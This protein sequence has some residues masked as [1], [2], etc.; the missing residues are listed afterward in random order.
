[1]LP[2]R[3]LFHTVKHLKARQVIYRLFYQFRTLQ[4]SS[5][6]FVARR[7]LPLPATWPAYKHFSTQDGKT[8]AFLNSI[9]DITGGWNNPEY[10]KLW[11]YKLHYL[12]DL[13]AVGA[14]RRSSLLTDMV[15]CW[16]R[17]N[18]LPRGNGWEPYPL[19]IRIV[20]LIKFL[21]TTTT[22]AD[23][24]IN[25]SLAL[26]VEALRKQKEVHLLG[27]HYFANAKALVFAGVF[28]EGLDAE[29]WLNE[30]LDI[31]DGELNEQFLKDGGHFEL[32]PM[33]HCILLWDLCDLIQL[34]RWSILA[35]LTK[36]EERLV[37]ALAAG[38]R[39]LREMTHPDGGISFF[40][41]A[42]FD[43]APT[44]GDIEAYAEKL[45]IEVLPIAASVIGATWSAKHMAASGYVSIADLPHR[46]YAIV[47]VAQIGPDYLPGHGHSDTLSF[48]LSLFGQRVFVNSGTSHYEASTREFE[49]STA[50]HNTV[51]VDG[52]SSSEVWDRFKVGRRARP[53][54]ISLIKWGACLK[55][56]GA[57]TGY[58][59]LPGK[60]THF[61]EW[62]FQERSITIQDQLDG[63]WQKAVA[64][65]YCHPS[66][67][68]QS[69]TVQAVILVLPDDQ[70]IS[71]EFSGA[72]TVSIVDSFWNKA[73]GERIHNKCV[74]VEFED[75]MMCSSLTW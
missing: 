53:R 59:R 56:A 48:E 69:S 41:D 32:S 65:F 6:Q 51:E 16:I 19:S 23:E 75:S 25:E 29:R 55:L 24:E 14:S 71:L 66:I 45:E 12:D 57:H 18:P 30:G 47:D 3:L 74:K 8:F 20:N 58:L 7:S 63:R 44:P 70:Q 61:R 31:L 52:V 73:F 64:R 11:L 43:E 46:H 26:Q 17:E 62:C 50:A 4:V 54:D 37:S 38:I 42:A 2:L 68:I 72:R 39:W 21:S 33:Y 35:E 40:N 15:L 1:M 27:N 60:V 9:G 10:T 36:R 49:R 5:P 13:S 28:F 22:A 67:R 34:T